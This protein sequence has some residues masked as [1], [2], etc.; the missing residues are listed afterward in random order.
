MSFVNPLTSP[1]FLAGME[2]LFTEI[3]FMLSAEQF[4]WAPPETFAFVMISVSSPVPYP[5]QLTIVSAGFWT[6]TATHAL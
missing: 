2:V 6:Q 4:E 3:N 1:C 5:S